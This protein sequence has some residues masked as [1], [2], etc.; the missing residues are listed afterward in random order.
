MEAFEACEWTTAK[1]AGDNNGEFV[2][3][4]RPWVLVVVRQDGDVL[5][6]RCS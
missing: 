5:G 3:F 2:W 4:E 1:G 6:G